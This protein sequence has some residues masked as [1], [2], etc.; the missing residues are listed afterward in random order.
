M[1]L[2]VFVDSKRVS[3]C[4][5]C[6]AVITFAELLSG[7]TMPFNGRAVGSATPSLL[8]GP[9]AL[10]DIDTTRHPSHFATCPNARQHRRN[11]TAR[12]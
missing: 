8:T 7:K 4:Q 2:T 5:S 3:Q 9:R 10:E 6:G 11:R 1:I 12:R